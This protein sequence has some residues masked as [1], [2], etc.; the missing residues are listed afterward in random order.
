MN[1]DF[2]RNFSFL[3]ARSELEGKECERAVPNSDIE[4]GE[5]GRIS[6]QVMVREAKKEG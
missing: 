6:S 2:T 3:R 5:R 4:E 1:S